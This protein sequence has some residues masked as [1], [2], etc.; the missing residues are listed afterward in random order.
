MAYTKLNHVSPDQY[1]YASTINKII[2]NFTAI[3]GADN[4]ST[5]LKSLLDSLNALKTKVDTLDAEVRVELEIAIKNVSNILEEIK[6]ENNTFKT[7]WTNTIHGM[8]SRLYKLVDS[9]GYK[10]ALN[11]YFN[12]DTVKPINRYRVVIEDK[13]YDFKNNN[14]VDYTFPNKKDFYSVLNPP[15]NYELVDNDIPNPTFDKKYKWVIRVD[16]Q[17]VDNKEALDE[18]DGST[19]IYQTIDNSKYYRFI[20][21]AW[22]EIV[23]HE[24]ATKDELDNSIVVSGEVLKKED[25][26]DAI[27]YK[28]RNLVL[29]I[30]K[31]LD[32]LGFVADLTTVHKTTAVGA[33]NELDAEVGDLATLSTVNNMKQTTIVATLNK[34]NELIGDLSTI[35][36]TNTNLRGASVVEAINKLD[37]MLGLFTDIAVQ[38]KGTTYTQ[39]FNNINTILGDFSSINTQIKQAD[40]ATTL[41]KVNELLGIV[42]NV[43][44]PEI[45]AANLVDIINNLKLKIGNIANMA[46]VNISNKG[47]S[48][49][50]ILNKFDAMF[51]LFDDIESQIKGITYTETFN[52]INKFLGNISSITDSEITAGNLSQIINNIKL[53]IGMLSDI[54]PVNVSNKS[55]S[56]VT[57]YN[58]LD[59]MLGL[60]T[61][62]N[63]QIKGSTYTETFNKINSLLGTVSSISDTEITASDLSTIINNLK[64]KLGTV[65]NISLVNTANRSNSIV[66]TYNNLDTMLGDFTT[67][68]VD[69]KG[70]SYVETFN[71]IK[72]KIDTKN[73]ELSNLIGTLSNI[74]APYNGNSVEVIISSLITKLGELD[75]KNTDLE[76]KNTELETK[77]TE[78]ETFISLAT[79]SVIEYELS[80]DT[81]NV[82]GSLEVPITAE[83]AWSAKSLSEDIAEIEIQSD[84]IIIN[85]I[86]ESPDPVKIE[87]S[88]ESDTEKGLLPNKVLFKISVT[89]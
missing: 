62:V 38:I 82:G 31:L 20:D 43:T 30:N 81:V 46:S 39:T 53:K 3:V 69:I 52:N 33:V 76:A 42:A 61:D 49:E 29:S 32:D 58:K 73:T 67:V 24:I 28:R 80:A 13:Y 44:D 59:A 40:L 23:K 86:L 41:N 77:I 6:K 85:G 84:K 27:G 22:T 87:I 79:P 70:V 17:T 8:D 47:D 66:E 51:G 60:F 14:W 74:Q 34:I 75:T 25:L 7:E 36:S 18:I 50:V 37:V 88:A 11:E 71:N 1:G 57:T 12:D 63:A 19:T 55:D 48:I 15:N 21:D 26:P 45:T 65:S 54:S 4:L 56:I 35:F 9:T 72:T 68:D 16:I 83:T 64:T 89:V 5:N 78:L 2:D 10:S